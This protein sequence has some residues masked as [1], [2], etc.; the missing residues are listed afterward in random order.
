MDRQTLMA[1]AALDAM[2]HTLD[3]SPEDQAL[4]IT[5]QVTLSCGQA[6]AEAARQHGC[7]AWTYV[8]PEHDRPLK[9]LPDGIM[10]HFD[11]ATVVINAISGDAREIPFRL[12]WINA[13]EGSGRIR[14]GHSPGINED[15]MVGGPLGVDYGLMQDN[16]DRLIGAFEDVNRVHITT[17]LGTDLELDLTGRQVV[18]DLK[19][20]LDGGVNMP[21]GE[22]YCCPVET[23]ANGQL[24][25]DGCFGSFGNVGALVTFTVTDG[26]VTD[27]KCA[28]AA[29][30]TEITKLLETDRAARTIAELGIGLNPGARLTSNMLEAEKV[31]GTAHIA[32]GSNEGMPGGRNVSQTHIDYLFSKPTMV[33]T[34]K[35]GRTREIMKEGDV[36]WPGL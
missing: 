8:L 19:A 35:D 5:D 4:I 31:A 24:I 25:I 6:F 13:I 12:Q 28:D 21:C 18:S 7:L 15:M 30:L 27:V 20:T 10:D 36:V 26:R 16:A 32:F 22:V 14:M 17:H 3:L 23:G 29:T 2:I 1:K 9:E 11:E 34:L 33:A